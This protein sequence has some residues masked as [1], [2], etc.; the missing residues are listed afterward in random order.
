MS[1]TSNAWVLNGDLS[2]A[3]AIWL[4]DEE[5][6]LL[7]KYNVKVV[8]APRPACGWAKVARIKQMMRS[9]VSVGLGCAR[10]RRATSFLSR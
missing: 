3:H 6:G 7:G 1:S 10:E 5:I 4:N 2:V 8:H 9:G